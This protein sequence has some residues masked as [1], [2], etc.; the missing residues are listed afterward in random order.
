MN[1]SI[2]TEHINESSR[3]LTHSATA[4]AVWTGF[5]LVGLILGAGFYG[6]WQLAGIPAVTASAAWSGTAALLFLALGLTAPNLRA[7]ILHIGF[8]LGLFWFATAL[9]LTS[10]LHPA[11]GPI[12]QAAWATAHLANDAETDRH[13]MLLIWAVANLVIASGLL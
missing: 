11:V 12:L 4:A 1:M 10:T 3:P 7:G 8:A 9:P 6:L 5:S 13:P 2:A